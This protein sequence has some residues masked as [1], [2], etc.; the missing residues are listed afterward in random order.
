MTNQDIRVGSIKVSYPHS[1]DELEIWEWVTFLKH[2]LSM[3]LILHNTPEHLLMSNQVA[4]AEICNS[5]LC[6]QEEDVKSN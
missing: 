3:L 1:F 4:V 2:Q 6:V 5:L